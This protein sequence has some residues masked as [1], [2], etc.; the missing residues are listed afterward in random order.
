MD[1]RG[2]TRGRF[3]NEPSLGSGMDWRTAIKTMV[4]DGVPLL[5][6]CVGLQWLFE[7]STEAPDVEG[8]SPNTPRNY[9]AGWGYI[10]LTRGLIWDGKGPFKLYA[11]QF[12]Y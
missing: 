7:D 6:I 5:G 2:R 1:F 4:D 11:D 12:S 3:T 10:M 8:L 9:L